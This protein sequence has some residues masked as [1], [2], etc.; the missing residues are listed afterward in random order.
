MRTDRFVTR[1]EGKL[2]VF[3]FSNI[4]YVMAKKNY[5][6]IHTVKGKYFVHL[7]IKCLEGILPGE[8]FCKIHRSCIVA[9]DHVEKI[10]HNRVYIEKAVLPLSSQYAETVLSNY[11]IVGEPE[12]HAN[13]SM[14]VSYLR[15][16]KKTG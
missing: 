5:A 11:K 12:L 3:I 2:Q 15:K 9:I 1:V 7:T 6:E 13:G 10:D 14:S 16:N 4:Y 8:L